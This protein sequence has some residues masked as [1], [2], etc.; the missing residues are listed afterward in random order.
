ME[1]EP[2]WGMRCSASGAKKTFRLIVQRGNG[3]VVQH[4]DG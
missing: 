3:F 1:G 4:V 2:L